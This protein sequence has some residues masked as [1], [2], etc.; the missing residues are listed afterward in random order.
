MTTV[1]V[2][3]GLRQLSPPERWAKL[4]V[5]L[6][7]ELRQSGL[8]RI[9]GF[10][11]L[12]ELARTRGR[13]DAEE[14]ALEFRHSGY[15]LEL[16][17]RVAI[18]A[19][20]KRLKPEVPKRWVDYHCED[21]FSSP[22]AEHGY[23]DEGGELWLIEPAERVEEYGEDCFLQIGRPGVDSIG[24]GYRKARSGFWAY[25]RMVDQVF[26]YLTPTLMTF[27]DGWLS[28]QIAV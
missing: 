23:W 20:L 15:G 27:L 11:A 8:G 4:V 16:T 13:I 14:L 7:E 6:A 28:A 22:F 21:Y 2:L 1:F 5:P 17:E 19:G 25:H 26:Q 9:V 18:A 12:E 10:D 3:T 24:F